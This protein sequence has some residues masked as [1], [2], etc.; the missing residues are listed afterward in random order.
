MTP[1]VDRVDKL[2]TQD[3][4]RVRFLAAKELESYAEPNAKLINRRAKWI[5]ASSLFFPAQVIAWTVGLA[6]YH[7]RPSSPARSSARAAST[8]E[9]VAHPQ[10][11]APNPQTPQGGSRSWRLAPY[12]PEPRRRDEVALIAPCLGARPRGQPATSAAPIPPWRLQRAGP[13]SARSAPAGSPH[14]R[15]E[16]PGARSGP[17]P[18]VPDRSRRRSPGAPIPGGS[19]S[20]RAHARPPQRRGAR[21]RTGYLGYL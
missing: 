7:H 19:A 11:C 4:E 6:V 15:T 17:P 12:D 2:Y 8:L 20:R 13:D 18:H 1:S 16:R 10:F 5:M 9:S 14:S 3:S 21:R